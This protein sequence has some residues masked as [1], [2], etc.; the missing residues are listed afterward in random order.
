MNNTVKIHI[1]HHTYSLL[2]HLYFEHS[3]PNT[4]AGRI[5]KYSYKYKAILPSPG[6]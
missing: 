6:F 2:A 1:N 4:G 5:H 3:S